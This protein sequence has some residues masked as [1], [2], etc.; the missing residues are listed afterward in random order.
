[1]VQQAFAVEELCLMRSWPALH[2]YALDGQVRQLMR[3]I[4]KDPPE[5]P[6]PSF[7]A[8]P[9]SPC[10][11]LSQSDSSCARPTRTGTQGA[12]IQLKGAYVCRGHIL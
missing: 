2:L 6:E 9:L 7:C 12:W 1:M 8:S 4:S 11:S 10:H 3:L 5:S